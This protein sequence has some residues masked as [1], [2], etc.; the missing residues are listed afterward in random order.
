MQLRRDVAPVRPPKPRKRHSETMAMIG[1]QESLAAFTGGRAGATSL[2]TAQ[3][4]FK[5]YGYD[6]HTGKPGGFYGGTCRSNVPPKHK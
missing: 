2:R 3:A 4:V 5:D 6:W 1:I